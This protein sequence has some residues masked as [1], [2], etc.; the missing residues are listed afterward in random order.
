MGYI[1]CHHSMADIV[2]IVMLLFI[3]KVVLTALLTNFGINASVDT[4][5]AMYCVIIGVVQHYIGKYT[6]SFMVTVSGKA[7]KLFKRQAYMQ[8]ARLSTE[9]KANTTIDKFRELVNDASNTMD[10]LFFNCTIPVF[11]LIGNISSLCIGAYMLGML[12]PFII[13]VFVFG[14]AYYWFVYRDMGAFT[15]Y[16]VSL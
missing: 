7:D 4:Y 12:I 15:K 8:Y 14:A 10:W 9:F 11:S 1:R 16:M 6:E 2:R 3:N 13:L 5:S